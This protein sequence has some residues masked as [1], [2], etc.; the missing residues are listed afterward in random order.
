MLLKTNEMGEAGLDT[1]FEL[2]NI[3][4]SSYHLYKRLDTGF[5]LGNIVM[6]S[7]LYERL[8][9]GLEHHVGVEEE[10]SEQGLRVAGKLAQNTRQQDVYIRRVLEHVFQLGKQ[11]H[12]ER[13]CR[14]GARER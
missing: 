3:V 12:H 9:A 2:G 14:G 6:S 8:D 10:R 13:T 7:Y 4:M 1:G 5:E 11:N